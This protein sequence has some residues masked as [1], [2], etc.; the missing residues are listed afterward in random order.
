MKARET[1]IEH[2]VL[3]QWTSEARRDQIDTVVRELRALEGK[4]DGIVHLTC[5]AD[6]SGRA[7]G[8]THALTVRF[9]DRAA[10]EAYGPHPAHQHVVQTYINPIRANVLAC[11]Y[12]I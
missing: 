8:F 12:E 6:F 10:L 7:H 1:M 9:V 4:I 5:G 2:I 11:D 3:F